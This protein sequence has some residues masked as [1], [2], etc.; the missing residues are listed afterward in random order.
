VA[1]LIEAAVRSGA[2]ELA[3]GVEPR[4][5]EMTAASGT[6]RALGVAARSR[7]LL[8]DDGEAADLYA[9]AIE[10]LGRSRMRVDLARA[11]LRSGGCT[12]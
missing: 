5:S 2:R 4:L 6:D 8:A 12:A 9:E 10:R 11:H 3:V 1:E 7:A